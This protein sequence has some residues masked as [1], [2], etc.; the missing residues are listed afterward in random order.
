M[1]DFLFQQI[2]SS[3]EIPTR[4]WTITGTAWEHLVWPGKSWTDLTHLFGC[5]RASPGR[6]YWWPSDSNK[7][8]AVSV[9]WL[10]E[11]QSDAFETDPSP[12][13][14]DQMAIMR[15]EISD[16][17]LRKWTCAEHVLIFFGKCCS[18][19]EQSVQYDLFSVHWCGSVSPYRNHTKKERHGTDC[20]CCWKCPLAMWLGWDS[21]RE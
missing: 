2:S 12:V 11:E 21:C 17:G 19:M 18:K 3:V 10:Q 16:E 5:W 7:D 14:Y 13:K 15:A 4:F 1:N 8:K 9:W 20:K 6:R